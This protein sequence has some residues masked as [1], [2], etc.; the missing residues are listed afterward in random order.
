MD[1]LSDDGHGPLEDVQRWSQSGKSGIFYTCTARSLSYTCRSISGP[2]V[3]TTAARLLGVVSVQCRGPHATLQDGHRECGGDATPTKPAAT[4][5]AAAAATTT[6]AARRG[7]RAS[8]VAAAPSSPHHRLGGAPAAVFELQPEAELVPKLQRLQ[9]HQRVPGKDAA[10]DGADGAAAF[11]RL[12]LGQ[13]DS[14]DAGVPDGDVGDVD[15]GAAD[16]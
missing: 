12:S 3:I 15:V 1:G 11:V 16:Q 14:D 13:E 7:C 6:T 10:A 8:P 5:A 2:R 4:A 9:P